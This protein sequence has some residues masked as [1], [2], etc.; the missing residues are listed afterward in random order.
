MD[1]TQGVAL[2][3]GSMGDGMKGLIEVEG[4]G[5]SY[6]DFQALKGVDFTI[7]DGEFVSIIGPSGCGKTTLLKILAGLT[8]A[9]AGEIRIEGTPVTGPGPDRA[10]VFQQFALFPWK[11]V[12]ANIAF[13]LR[14]KGVAG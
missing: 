12:Q 6:G 1:G 5:K 7:R 8:P 14:N 4:L 10:V 13:G 3:T 2:A 9:S 11:T